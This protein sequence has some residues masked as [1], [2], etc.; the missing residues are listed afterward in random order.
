MKVH[1]QCEFEM[2]GY[3]S[4]PNDLLFNKDEWHATQDGW[5][6]QLVAAIEG[7]DGDELLNTS[8][9]DLARYYVDKYVFD[10]PT[11]Y[12]DELVV[13]QRETQIDVS[14]DQNRMIHDRSRPYHMAGTSLDVEIPYSGN[15]VGFDI[16]PTTWSTGKPRANVAGNVL[17]FSIVGTDLT[18]DSV[19]R[20]IERRISA[21]TEHIGWLENDAK[22]YN[23]SLDALATQ[24]IERR[25]EK[26][27][28]D[29]SL[30]AGLGFKMKA[31]PG[32]SETFAAPNVRRKI[33]P[34]T[35]KPTASRQAFKPEPTLTDQDYEHILTVLENM[36]GVMEQSPGAF[37]EIDEESLR[38]H[39]LV[40]LNG[41]F[42]GDATGETFNYEGK[43]D[44][45]I[46]VDG[47]NIF[48]GECKF[49]TG[50]KGYLETL[51]QVLSYLSWRDTKA[52]VL[53]FSR[54]KDF[55]G[56]LSKIE[57]STAKHPSFKKQ[58]S[59]RSESSWTYL[60]GHKDDANR[61]ISIT[62]QAYNVP[63]RIEPRIRPLGR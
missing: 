51:D 11:I 57:E 59:K 9:T 44:I 27:L 50:E 54:N 63:E 48:I 55:T 7:M 56:V 45:L 32:Q 34:A 33:R 37:R 39:F 20:E 6:K 46:K 13:D 38:T 47:K 60:F 43:T 16:Q 5:K 2:R 41:H 19:R 62:V 52:A 21:L 17:K 28:K 12:P 15:K 49:W 3:N 25:K 4:A 31:R 8:T 23:A 22:G 42:S 18:E 10:A 29:K 58:V 14:Q 30:V 36:V 26:L 35:P 53:V 24:T 40:Q 1:T 61:E